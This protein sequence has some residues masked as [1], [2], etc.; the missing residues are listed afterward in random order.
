MRARPPETRA[1]EG[2]GTEL[3]GTR[4]RAREQ[5]ERGGWEG[6]REKRGNTEIKGGRER[7][8]YKSARAVSVALALALALALSRACALRLSRCLPLSLSLDPE[9]STVKLYTTI[10]GE[11]IIVYFR[12]KYMVM[13][14]RPPQ[15]DTPAPTQNPVFGLASS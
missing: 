14:G 7:Y 8:T 4:E 6:E 3:E 12:H 11:K 1:R 15:H 5:G 10:G 2:G 9:D 13:G